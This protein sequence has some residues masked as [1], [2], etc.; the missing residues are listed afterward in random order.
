M[1][2]ASATTRR[3]RRAQAWRAALLVTALLVVALA[4]LWDWNWFRGT[5]ERRVEA[6]TGREFAIGGDLDVDLGRVIVIRVSDLTLANTRWSLTPE[7]A[8]ADLLRVEIPFWPLLRG[9]RVLRRTDLVRPALLLERNRRGNA[10]WHFE[11]KRP[12]RDEPLAWSFGEV[13]IHDG[14]LD[15]R[16]SPLGTN[17]RLTVDSATP[18]AGAESVR[19]LFR[20]SGRYRGHPFQLDGWA[21]SP[22]ALLE[23]AD[24]A[25]RLEIAARAGTTRGRAHGA[26]KVPIDPAR[27]RVSVE[28]SGNDL[29]DLYPLLGLAVPSTPPYRLTGEL[30]RDGR[31]FT[32]H[33]MS[34]RVGDSD[35]QGQVRVDLTGERAHLEADLQSS[36][37]D[38]DDLG[39]LLGLP[40]GTGA[41]ESASPRQR[42]EARRR[43]AGSRLLP[44]RD[45]DLRKLSSMDATVHLHAD[46]VD[47]G[48]WPVD[49]FAMNLRLRKALLELD[50]LDI[51]FAGGR[52]AGKVTLD[53]RHE[54]IAA[55]A[56]LAVR[57]VDLE[58][59]WPDMDPANVGRLGGR[60][61]LSGRG[62]SIA[63]MFATADG[64]VQAAMGAGRFSNLLLELA[65]LDVAETL[66][67]LL[68]KDRTVP[69][70]CA[71]GDFAFEDGVMQT[72]ALVFD[73]T[74]TVVFG[75]GSIR[76]DEEKLALEIRPQPKDVSPFSLRGPLDIGG[77]LKKPQF[78]PKPKPLLARALA[79]AALY[80]VAPPAALLAFIETGPG[81][82]IDCHGSGPARASRAEQAEADGEL[83]GKPGAGAD[84]DAAEEPA[85]EAKALE[86]DEEDD[87]ERPRSR[88]PKQP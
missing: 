9:E 63:D 52:V 40:P 2:D 13:R 46:R 80:A 81:E 28:L 30:E 50:P 14:R 65:G 84:A 55:G 34:G 4:V 5:I 41:D 49:S 66:K 68:G 51:G 67:F 83:E 31:S 33:E 69:L 72:R 76:F 74:D 24:A 42:E 25:Y 71:Y 59:L 73:T 38:L 75:S 26:L 12:R 88:A 7:M 58:H 8:R 15:V 48:K 39:G 29:E 11:P 21:D 57:D 45:Y 62:N 70:R 10:N 22:V 61:D 3:E 18:Q 23:R 87:D 86:E 85:S 43:A 60:I 53:A 78:S 64:E 79:A 77:T 19:L 17:L 6:A 16:D 56:E 82:D 44:D 37:L 47:A 32:L 20:G 1:T 54:V 36:N 35:V 27:F